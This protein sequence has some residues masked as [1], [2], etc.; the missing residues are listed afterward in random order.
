MKTIISTCFFLALF[1]FIKADSLNELYFL[2]G[3]W[4]TENKETYETWEKAADGTLEGQ[5]YKIKDGQKLVTEYLRI[6]LI[7]GKAT[8]QARV[9]NQ[10]NNR[11]I[12]FVLNTDVK[13]KFSFENLSH[14]FPR[15]IQYKPID[16]RTIQVSVLGEGEKGFGY[17]ILKQ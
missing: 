1:S 9:P 12:A 5:G 17:R 4:K 3:T 2:E 11:T 8:Y 15:K 14:D 7:D 10:N 6:N 16:A 13:D